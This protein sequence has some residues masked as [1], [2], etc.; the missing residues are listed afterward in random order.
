MEDKPA[1]RLPPAKKL[2]L[3]KETLKRVW[4]GASGDTIPTQPGSP[5]DCNTTP[6]CTLMTATH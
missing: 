2:T 6:D 5:H 1:K 4:G 3:H